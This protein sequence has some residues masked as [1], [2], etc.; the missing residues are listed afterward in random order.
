M[1]TPVDDEHWGSELD[2]YT[3]KQPENVKS[4]LAGFNIYIKI[5]RI[6]D[7]ML[8]TIVGLLVDLRAPVDLTPPCST[9]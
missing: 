7:V 6:Q 5:I 2:G 3:W 4:V 8:R 1:P 9:R